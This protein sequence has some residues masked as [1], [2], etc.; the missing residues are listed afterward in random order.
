[1]AEPPDSQRRAGQNTGSPPR[2]VRH[3]RIFLA[4]PGDVA[5]ERKIALEAIEQ[6]QYERQFRG[7]VF[8]EHVAWDNPGTGTLMRATISPQEAIA[9][10]SGKP[11]DCD[12]VVVIFWARMGRPLPDPPYHHEAG[13]RPYHSGTEWEYENAMEGFLENKRPEVVVYRRTEKPLFSPRDSGFESEVEQWKLVEKFF[14]RF[15][16]PKT[17]AIRHGCN[18]YASPDDFRQQFTQHLRELVEELLQAPASAPTLVPSPPVELWRESPFPGLRAFTDRDSPIFFGR[19]RE[20]DNLVERI[21]RDRFVAVVGA[22]GSGK[23][24]LVWAGLIPALKGNSIRSERAASSDWLWVRMTP[25]GSRD[26]PDNPFMALA[27]ELKRYLAGWE[28]RD[29]ARELAAKPEAFTQLIPQILAGRPDWA[30]LL[31]FI[32]QFEE[33]VTVVAD[34]Y[35]A[36]FA[37]M[38]SQAMAGG[39]FRAVATLRADFYH[40]MIPLSPALVELL[41]NGSYPLGVPDPLSLREMIVRPAERAG[42]QFEGDLAERIVRDTGTEPGGLALMAYLL[43]ELHSD[44]HRSADGRLSSRAYDDLGKVEGAIGKR[45]EQAFN[46]LSAEAQRAL[47][48]VFRR[49][50]KVDGSG[51]ATR[52]RAPQAELE[53]FAPQAARELVR[54]FT[55]ARLLV[56]D[57]QG[58][59]P[60]AK[61]TVEVAHEALLRKWDRLAIWIRQAQ[62]DLRLLDQMKLASE[63]WERNSR[64]EAYRWPHE[65]LVPLY[66]AIDRLA[67]DKEQEFSAAELEFMRSESDRLLE[68]IQ[69]PDTPHIRRWQI[70]ERVAI[71]GD[72][73]PSAGLLPDGLPDI[74]WCKVE[75]PSRSSVEVKIEEVGKVKVSLPF[76][77]ARYPITYVQFQAF[78]RAKDGYE[79]K[80]IDW[81]E[82]LAAGKER[83]LEEQHFKFDN[84]PRETVNWYE[85]IA[86]CRWL[87]WRVERMRGRGESSSLLVEEGRVQAGAVPPGEFQSGLEAKESS[88]LPPSK[89]T[90]RSQPARGRGFDPMNPFTWAVRL[91]TEAEWQFAA[92]GP[93]AKMYPWGNG[94]DGRLANTAESGLGRTTAVG[95]YPA[96]AGECGALDMSGNVW[97]WTLTEHASGKADDITNGEPRVVRGGSWDLNQDSARAAY[98]YNHPLPDPRLNYIGFRVVW[99][100]PSR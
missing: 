25:G 31:L 54:E 55:K 43:D 77:I 95:M 73:R 87:S 8:L 79:N 90:R 52:R 9:H 75:L 17:G 23:S 76:Y 88:I 24:S 11:A 7:K 21:K 6:L 48:Q 50:V 14:A 58:A 86:F 97:E 71:I 66:E 84:H 98:L 2:Y 57:T 18:F 30:E 74:N 59:K 26:N 51:T 34:R 92:A 78:I 16:D 39:R 56:A 44:P 38:L 19:G 93:S 3:F 42:L 62:N 96:G 12:I 33:L 47:P 67:V 27:V 46:A 68:E 70:G 61:P 53:R 40:Q 91:P 85:A 64:N 94:W 45:A 5:A 89:W 100:V 49:L 20:T 60:W 10:G 99:V 83:R 80:E 69:N 4:S 36:P 65:R 41:Q 81:F 35:R 15:S 28:A 82:G 37:E 29:T 63:E 13:N 1:M 72:P 22:S 32:D